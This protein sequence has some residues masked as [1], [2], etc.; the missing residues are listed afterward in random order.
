MKKV[1]NKIKNIVDEINGRTDTAKEQ[2]VIWK[3]GLRNSS[4]M[5]QKRVRQERKKIL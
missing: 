5:Q 4:R 3:I 1:S 2:L